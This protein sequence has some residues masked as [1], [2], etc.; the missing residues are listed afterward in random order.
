MFNDLESK[1]QSLLER[2]ITS[3]LELE[4]WLFDELRVNAEI[5]EKITSSLI[6]TYRDT[7]N[8]NMHDLHMYNQNTIQPLLKRYNAKFD[9]KFIECPFSNLLDER[10]YAFMKKARFVKSKMFNEKNIA[11]SIKEQ[12]C[13]TKYREIMSNITINWE[14]EQ[15]TYA[16]VKAKLDNPNRAIR[17]KAWYALC[18]ARSAVK[19]E[20][21]RI[22]NELIQLRNEIALNAGFNNYS[23]YACKQKNRDYNIEDCYKLHESIEKYVVP[24]W[25]QLG[26]ISKKNLGVKTYRP[27]DLSPCNL[28]KV[29]FQNVIDLLNGVEEIFRKTDLYFYEKFIHIRKAGCIDVEERENKA[30]G[31]ICFTLPHSKEVFVYSNFSP[32]FYA[33]NALIHEVGHAFHFYK[34]FKNDSSMQERYLREEVAELYSLSLELLVMDKLNVFYKQ[35]DEYKE[36]QRVQIYRAL[37]L[38]MSSIAGDVFQH[39]IYANPNH[40]SEERDKKYAELCKRYQY[41]TVDLAGLEDEIGASWIESFH[42]VQFPFYKIEYAIAQI[43]AMQLFQI[44]WEDPEKAIAFFKEGASADW[45]LSIQ[46]IYE[47]TGVTFDF[48]EERIESTASV[49]LDVINELK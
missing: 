17:E 49:I 18:E 11:L 47:K 2:N 34:Q 5:E 19:P 24:I 1:L 16:H 7:G 6:A 3:V 35:E 42:Y 28:P 4:N 23:E 37:S 14:G 38:L 43:G 26:S 20:V 30:P 21:D 33:I 12:E 48:S 13:I 29:P 44:Y 31:A 8:R 22:M 10:K 46:E 9:Q 36:V 25:K 41:S 40:T 15:K 27:W 45:N 39:W 32:S